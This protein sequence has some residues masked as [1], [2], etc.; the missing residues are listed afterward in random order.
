MR[1]SSWAHE[2]LVT[3]LAYQRERALLASGARDG[4]VAVWPSV[5]GAARRASA[6]R[7]GPP[8][9]PKP[10]VVLRAGASVGG[11]AWSADDRD[12][13]VARDDGML[14]ALQVEDG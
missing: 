4:V 5:G 10:L 12:V 6:R 7:G 11:V 8:P 13:L 3:A 1:R 2:R 9:G 14:S